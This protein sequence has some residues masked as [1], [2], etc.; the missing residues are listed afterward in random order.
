MQGFTTYAPREKITRIVRGR[1]QT[2]SRYL[3][4][5]YLFVWIGEQWHKLFSIVG[6]TRVLMTGQE[7]ARLPDGWVDGMR[8][9][10]RNGLIVLPKHR[11][12]IGQ[13][14]MVGSGLLMGQRGLYQGMGPRQ[15]EIVLLEALGRVELS[16][17]LLR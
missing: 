14:V 11:F 3:F 2:T 4:P 8:S 7:P 6:L 10:E 1:K 12:K 16:P 9:T 15:R 17:G 5:R 13:S